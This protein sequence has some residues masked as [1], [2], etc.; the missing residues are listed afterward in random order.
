MKWVRRLAW[1]VAALLL[2]WGAAW[3]AVPPLVKWQAEKRLTELTGRQVTLGAVAFSPWA[4]RLSL[5]DLAVAPAPGAAATEPQFSLAG[6]TVDVDAASLLRLA[7]VVSSLQIDTPRLRVA[8]LAEGRYDF[9]DVL[10]RFVSPPDAPARETPRFAVYNVELRHGELWF[11]DLPVTKRHHLSELTLAMPF[12]SSLKADVEVK[13]EPRLAFKLNGAGYDSSAQATP[14]APRRNGNLGL[15]ITAFEFEPYLGYLPESLP[16]RLRRGRV[17]ADL[18]LDFAAPADAAPSVSLRGKVELADVAM[19]ERGGAPLLAVKQLALALDDV[20]PLARK[21]ALGALRID[22]LE[23]HLSRDAHGAMSLERLRPAAAP[24]AAPPASA[25]SASAAPMANAPAWQLSLASFDLAGARVLWDDAAVQPASAWALEDVTLS[26]YR[27]SLPSTAP[28]PFAFEAALR[29]QAASTTTLA[30]IAVEG[31][32]TASA[33]TAKLELSNVVLAAVAPYLNAAAQVQVAGT[34]AARGT[35]QW[36]AK[37]DDEAQRLVVSLAELT[38]DGLKVGLPAAGKAARAVDMLAAQR[39]QV[40]DMALD[41]ATQSVAIA[42]V[43]LQRPALA[44]ERSVEGIWNVTRVAKPEALAESE[45]ALVRAAAELTWQLKL[46]ELALEDGRLR[47]NDAAPATV[48]AGDVVQPVR[49]NVDK[50]GLSVKNVRLRGER[51]VSTP[52]VQLSARVADAGADGR[53]LAATAGLIDWRGQFGLEP[54]NVKGKL[55]VERLPLH[56]VRAYGVHGLGL[57]LMHADAGFKGDFSLRHD[58]E[59]GL[60]A[61][62]SGDVLLSELRVDEYHP[63]VDPQ[64]TPGE[65]QLLS[66]QSL[67]VN[68]LS[69]ALR[70]GALPKVIVREA[71]LSDYFASLVLTEQG[72]LNLRRVV[73]RRDLAAEPAAAPASGAAAAPAAPPRPAPR[74]AP[75]TRR[76]A[77]AVASAASSATTAAANALPVDLDMG[78]VRLAGGNVEFSDHFVKPNYSARLTELNGSLGAFR[79]GSGDPAVLQLSGRVAGTGLLEIGGKLKPGSV[80]RELDIAAK[81]TDIELAPLSAY[82]GKYA[83]YAIERGKLSVDVHYRIDPDG[84]LDAS[85]QLIL[86]QL[87]FGDRVESPDATKLPVRF[88]VSLLKDKNGVIDL[89]LPVSGTIDDP[90]FSLGPLIWKVIVNLIGKI[91]SAPF[92]AFGGGGGPDLSVVPFQPG[93]GRPTESGLA[94]IDKV[95]KALTDRPSLT[96]TVT[97]EAD[98]DA[99]REAYQ[100]ATL[101]QRLL[102]EQRREQLRTLGPPSGA[103]PGSASGAASAPDAAPTVLAEPDRARLVKALY[104]QTDLPDKPRNVIGLK[105]DIPTAEMEA[106]L[107]AH[108]PA[109]PE[110]M[111]ELALQRGLYVRDALVARG[112]A[113][114]RLFLGDPKLRVGAAG[115]MSAAGSASAAGVAGAGPAASAANSPADAAWTPHVRLTLDAK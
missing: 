9:D 26:A 14:F 25:A 59:A 97:G 29:P 103:A 66:W 3:L 75:T 89:N 52:Q 18:A 98:V 30:G 22:G 55:R 8:R 77:S 93:T 34:G 17:D 78:G 4:L 69:V 11:N 47:F 60:S 104:R 83:G 86:N 113:S 63:T 71:T 42:S 50:L 51:L 37:S 99:E 10:Q 6:L 106:L 81:A 23:L 105:A 57:R 88:V 41:L 48:K 64:P 49:L 35:L 114:D 80:P 31:E 58:A 84:K 107:R 54:L 20:Q 44:L 15:R 32:A 45:R 28:M 91:I 1:A 111:R 70:P 72:E 87:T 13:V 94:A 85:H 73:P 109:G 96:M 82:S 115:A 53:D 36:A 108:V 65:E 39:L 100:R 12:L 56:A 74:S 46:G 110:A 24:A 92:S 33:A 90:Q 101:E 27:L 5:S 95:A 16:V 21:V 2:L 102:Q 7:P 68:G 79:T 112:L 76:I 43:K 40:K 19:D 61:D 67:A 38:L 62:L